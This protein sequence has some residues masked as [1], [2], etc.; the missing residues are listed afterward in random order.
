MTQG[1]SHNPVGRRV[2]DGGARTRRRESVP[3]V[4]RKGKAL[5]GAGVV[6]VC[7]SLLIWSPAVH[8]THWDSRQGMPSG[9][10][11]PQHQHQQKGSNC[12]SGCGGT[13]IT[14]AL[15]DTL[16]T[17]HRSNYWL[18]AIDRRQH[19]PQQHQPTSTKP[20]SA[21]IRASHQSPTTPGISD[22]LPGVVYHLCPR[23][24]ALESSTLTE[25]HSMEIMAPPYSVSGKDRKGPSR[26]STGLRI[27]AGSCPA[28]RFLSFLF[29]RP[30]WNSSRWGYS[31][32]DSMR[33][34]QR[35]GKTGCSDENLI[36]TSAK[37]GGWAYQRRVPDQPQ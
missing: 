37:A 6:S 32:H 36:F 9:S 20:D 3:V 8:C 25:F 29:R 16:P 28:K 15:T 19:H 30:V 11:V 5:G 24:I 2:D 23:S 4:G 34:D 13:S 33:C 17:W 27:G 1:L 31:R 35:Q 10:V 26:S 7:W 18:I 22:D 12:G 14:V 21:S